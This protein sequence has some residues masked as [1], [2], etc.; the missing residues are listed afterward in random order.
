MNR[1]RIEYESRINTFSWTQFQEEQRREARSRP[2]RPMI[3]PMNI[4]PPKPIKTIVIDESEGST[5]TNIVSSWIAKN[6]FMQKPK[7]DIIDIDDTEDS[8][9]KNDEMKNVLDRKELVGKEEA[10]AGGLSVKPINVIEI[11][12][13][14]DDDDIIVLNSPPLKKMTQYEA[15]TAETFWTQTLKK[16]SIESKSVLTANVDAA[17][18]LFRTWN[19]VKGV[20]PLINSIPSTE[21]T[22]CS[23]NVLC[24]KTIARTSYLYKHLRNTPGLLEWDYRWKGLRTELRNFKADIVGLQEVQADH[25]T[26]DFAPFM[27]GLG[28]TGAYKRKFGTTQKDDG[29]AIFY[30]PDKFKQIGYEEVNF[31]VS[32]NATSNRENIAQLMVLQCHRTCQCVIVANTHLIFNQERGDVKLAQLAILFANIHQMHKNFLMFNPAVIVLGDFNIEPYSKIYDFIVT[33]QLLVHGELV[34]SMSGQSKRTDGMLCCADKLL[35]DTM[36]DL[37]SR[38]RIMGAPI[39][40]NDGYLRHQF[41]FVSAYHHNVPRSTEKRRPISTYHKDSASPDFIFYTPDTSNM[42]VERL[43]LLERYT[44]PTFESLQNTV[45]WPNKSVPSDHIPIMAKFRLYQCF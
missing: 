3:P 29:C 35:C 23:Y 34:R 7:R 28:Y 40:R 36:I 24:Q 17:Q 10:V 13:D 27:N 15:A 30:R 33:G 38:I 2:S 21:F 32:P 11:D 25:F 44:L 6:R 31:F 45:P 8:A 20:Q 18:Q 9:D 12:D 39:P 1:N 19:Q 43:Q 14:E 41:Q 5:G 16:D 37:D 22:I 42:G 26:D 4:R